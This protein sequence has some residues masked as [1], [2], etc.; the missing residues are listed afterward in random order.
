MAYKNCFS[1]KN[2]IKCLGTSIRPIT[3]DL[4]CIVLRRLLLALE[5]DEFFH[6][7]VEEAAK[8]TIQTLLGYLK[9]AIFSENLFLEMFEDEYYQIIVVLI[10]FFI[11]TY[12]FS[13]AKYVWRL[14]VKILVYICLP[15]IHL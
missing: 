4:C 9:N 15:A 12:I 11:I 13:V 7:A 10:L 3:V 6:I 5:S 1:E 8:R 2:E 14:L